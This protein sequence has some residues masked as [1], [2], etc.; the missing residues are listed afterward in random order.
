MVAVLMEALV[1]KEASVDKVVLDKVV[2]DKEASDKVVLDK[3][4]LDK[5]V[6]VDME[7]SGF[8]PLVPRHQLAAT[9]ARPLK[10]RTTAARTMPRL[11]K[12]L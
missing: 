4:V 7:V 11:L 10:A 2:L 1:D 6:S 12:T 3:V 5:V 9:G 8:L